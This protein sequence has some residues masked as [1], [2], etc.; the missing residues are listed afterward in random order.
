MSDLARLY[1]ELNT[2]RW[3]GADEGWELAIAAVR[4]RIAQEIPDE[5]AR[6]ERARAE[7]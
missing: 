7:D 2:L 5:V 3:I 6:I 4:K 1:F